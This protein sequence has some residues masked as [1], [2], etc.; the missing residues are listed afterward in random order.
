LT[1]SVISERA[2]RTEERL[3]KLLELDPPELREYVVEVLED[4]LWRK[5]EQRERRTGIKFVRGTHGGTFVRDPE[6]TDI[7]PAGAQPPP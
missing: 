4:R 3:A 6:G 7:L 2:K 5:G 1:R